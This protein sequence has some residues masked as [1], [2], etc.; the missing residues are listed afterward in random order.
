[1]P[2]TYKWI[3]S[4]LECY[5]EKEDKQDVV[6]IIHWR[7]QAMDSGYI[8]EIYGDQFISLDPLEPFTPY[9]NLTEPQVIGWLESSLGEKTLAAQKISLDKQIAD[10][11]DP[12]VITPP[13]PWSN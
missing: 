2:T 9:P 5:P 7:R 11:I 3:I 8:A 6:F 13:I 12:P 4:S 10:Q 1:M